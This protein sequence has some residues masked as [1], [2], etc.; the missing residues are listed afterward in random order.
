[1]SWTEEPDGL[2]S[3]GI[4]KTEQPTLTLSQTGTCQEHCQRLND[5]GMCHLT[6]WEGEPCAAAAVD[7]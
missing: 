3:T 6:L 4:T 2:Q 7:L 1:M 5:E